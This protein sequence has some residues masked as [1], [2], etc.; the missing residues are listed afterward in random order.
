MADRLIAAI[1]HAAAI[2]NEAMAADITRAGGVLRCRW[3]HREQPLGD[4]ASHLR[5]GWP[6]CCLGGTM[7]W[8][9]QRQLDKEAAALLPGSD[10]A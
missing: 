5:S 3:C 7:T 4:A 2:V 6:T 10:H 8:V 9:T 1:Q